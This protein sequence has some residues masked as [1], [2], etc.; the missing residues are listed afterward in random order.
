MTFYYISCI[1]SL[2]GLYNIYKP[3]NYRYQS[4]VILFYLLI[5]FIISTFRFQVG[6]DWANY[7]KHFNFASKMN[8]DQF[9]EYYTVDIGYYLINRYLY[10]FHNDISALLIF[11]YVLFLITLLLISKELNQ[12]SSFIIAVIPISIFII[13]FS[14]FKQFIAILFYTISIL[15]FRNNIIIFLLFILGILFHRSLIF[16]AIP[17]IILTSNII[18]FRQLDIKKI[19]MLMLI[20]IISLIVL[21]H[22]SLGFISLIRNYFLSNVEIKLSLGVFMKI[23]ITII[24]FYTIYNLK[25]IKKIDNNL[26]NILFKVSLIE[27]VIIIFFIFT[28]G[29]FSNPISRILSYFFIIDIFKIIFYFKYERNNKINILLYTY[30]ILIINIFLLLRLF[31]VNASSWKLINLNLKDFNLLI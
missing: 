3:Q 6:G 8:L 15:Y 31:G 24:S 1:F 16:V 22:P 19:L 21:L 12:I 5:I 4:A 27:L 7:V 20:L 26:I 23:A 30:I 18:T 9:Y 10:L 25:F 14:N 17:T 13:G 28:L 11:I 29:Y 2:Y